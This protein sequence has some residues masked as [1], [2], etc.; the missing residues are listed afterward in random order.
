MKTLFISRLFFILEL[1]IVR[2]LLDISYIYF[3]S[4]TFAYEGYNYDV[5]NLSYKISWILY[6]SVSLFTPYCMNKLS[7]FFFAT[8]TL[9]LL[10]PLTSIYGLSERPVF[11]VI[12]S[13]L[14]LGCVYYIA[15]IKTIDKQQTNYNPNRQKAAVYISLFMVMYL[16]FWY[17][18]NGSFKNFNLNFSKVYDYREIT[19][20]ASDIGILSYVNNWVYQ[21]FS[22]F[23]IAY[24]ILKKK[25]FFVATLVIVQIFFFAVSS[26]KSVLFYPFLVLFV[27]L[28]F[29]KTKS[30][31]ILPIMYI[32]I[33][34][35]SLYLFVKYEYIMIGSMF[36]RR[37]FYV[38][39][40]LTYQ[41]FDFFTENVHT[42]WSNSILSF[43]ISY[44]YSERITILVGDYAGTGASANNGFISSG[45]G[46]AGIYGVFLY[47]FIIGFILNLLNV[48]AKNFTTLWFPVVVTIIPLRTLLLSSDLFTTLLTHGLLISI[49]LLMLMKGD[50]HAV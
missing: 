32:L 44:P 40:L 49:G 11:P 2:V 31:T 12:I 22:L 25:Y 17:F 46:H 3:V 27:S 5:N 35:L 20:E 39:S 4:E 21:V 50:R 30:L 48:I 43:F 26:H 33:L 45:Y 8:A 7:D 34:S 18:I 29:N 23:L 1:L 14:S 19:S 47:T 13:I 41:Y 6:L 38:P 42:Y 10:A 36:I 15:N 24:T 37:V 28:Y 16:V 9:S